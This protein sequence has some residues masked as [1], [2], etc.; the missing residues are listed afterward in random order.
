MNPILL[1]TVD[2]NSFVPYLKERKKENLFLHSD[3]N[4]INVD[5]KTTYGT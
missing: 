3:E 4:N 2:A 1:I 5:G